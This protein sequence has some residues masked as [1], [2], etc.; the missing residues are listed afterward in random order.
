[1]VWWYLLLWFIYQ[2]TALTSQ[3]V[4]RA[5]S[6]CKFLVLGFLLTWLEWERERK[7]RSVFVGVCLHQSD[8]KWHDNLLLHAINYLSSSNNNTTK[9]SKLQSCICVLLSLQT[10]DQETAALESIYAYFPTKTHTDFYTMFDMN[11]LCKN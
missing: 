5:H 3:S 1:M 11:F 7:A 10:L 8:I 6:H 4:C 2:S 9:K